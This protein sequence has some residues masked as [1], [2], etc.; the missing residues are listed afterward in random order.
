MKEN[1]CLAVRLPSRTRCP[2]QVS[3]D[4]REGPDGNWRRRA[5]VANQ[6]ALLTI[7]AIGSLRTA[8]IAVSQFERERERGGGRASKRMR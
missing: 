1:A 3:G 2:R 8:Y 4:V 7:A 6:R 5:G